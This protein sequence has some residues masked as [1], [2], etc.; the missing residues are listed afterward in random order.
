VMPFVEET[1]FP[2]DHVVSDTVD[3][4]F[5]FVNERRHLKKYFDSQ[6]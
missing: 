3:Q 1:D 4:V 6:E 2:R 5:N